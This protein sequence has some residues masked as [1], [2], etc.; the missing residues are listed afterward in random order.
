MRFIASEL[1]CL[2]RNFLSLSC[3]VHE[4]AGTERDAAQT[5]WYKAK[6]AAV[7]HGR[8]PREE[9]RLAGVDR[10]RSR[11]RFRPLQSDP[12]QG[13]LTAR[14]DPTKAMLATETSDAPCDLNDPKTT[15]L[16]GAIAIR[17]NQVCSTKRE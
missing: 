16:A 1:S 3:L 17:T 10:I 2:S 6:R 11:G 8:M 13:E 7:V 15:A 5:G 12:N 4:E 9:P 14:I